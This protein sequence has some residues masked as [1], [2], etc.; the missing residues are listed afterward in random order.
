MRKRKVFIIDLIS[1]SS[2]ILITDVPA[3]HIKG[4]MDNW[5]SYINNLSKDY[6]VR[7]LY[8]SRKDDHET[9][10]IIDYKEKYYVNMSDGESLDYECKK[11]FAE[12]KKAM[13]GKPDGRNYDWYPAFFE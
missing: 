5:D 12:N 6:Y 8:D 10:G 11:V 7:V 13:K 3:E 9:A 4:Q 2:V 1:D